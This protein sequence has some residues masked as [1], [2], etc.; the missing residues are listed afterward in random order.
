MNF[1]KSPASGT[2]RVSEH[3]RMPQIRTV[4]VNQYVSAMYTRTYH[5][6]M[7]IYI[8]IYIYIYACIHT[9]ILIYII[10]MYVRP[11]I[12]TYIRMLVT[13]PNSDTLR[14]KTFYFGIVFT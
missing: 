6:Y 3:K 12:L 1:T 7:H 8:Y 9:Y 5:A 11:L 4:R 13:V 2:G 14:F 10:R